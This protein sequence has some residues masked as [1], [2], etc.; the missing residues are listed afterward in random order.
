MNLEEELRGKQILFCVP[1]WGTDLF[2][3]EGFDPKTKSTYYSKYVQRT[4]H[5]C[6]TLCWVG[7]RG[8]AM[9]NAGTAVVFCPH[10][11][12]KYASQLGIDLANLD[13][14]TLTSRD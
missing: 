3:S 7:E 9:L 1:V 10:C 12:V 4:C 5:F 6:P 14:T 2:A 13:M 11:V 8:L